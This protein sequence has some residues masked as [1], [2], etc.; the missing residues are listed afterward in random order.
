MCAVRLLRVSV[1]ERISAAAEDF[2]LQVEKGGETAEIPAL[3]ALLTER[4]TAAAEEIIGLL[5]ETVAE[6][7]G[8]VERS[9]REICRQRRLLDAVLKP[10]VR[11]H[12][13]ALPSDILKVIV[14]EDELQQRSPSPDQEDAEPPH[15][16]EEEEELWSSQEGEQL[17]GLE[18]AEISRST[19][20]PVPVK[21][22]DD[23]EKPQ[24]SQLH[25]TQ[26]EA[27][28]EA[29]PSGCGSAELIKP[30]A[31]AESE[32]ST[33]SDTHL[34]PGAED[35]ASDSSDTEVSDGDWEDTREPEAG[36]KPLRNSR[37]TVIDFNCNTVERS[38]S[39]SECGQRFGRKPH[40]NAHMRIHTG[41]KPFSCS[42]CGKRF[43]QKGN[44]VSHM[45]LHTGEKPFSCSV[46]KKRFRYSGDVSRHMRIHTG[47]KKSSGTDTGS[48][49]TRTSGPHRR[50]PPS[51]DDQTP[52]PEADAADDGWRESGE[53]L[54]HLN[55]QRNEDV[56]A[57]ETRCSSDKESFSCSECGRTFCRKDHLMSHM[58]T[59][60]GE[61]PFSCSVCQKRFSCSGNILAHMRIHTGEKP[62]QCSFCSKSFSQK[63]T[64]QLH[65]RIHTGEKPFSCPFCDKRFAHKRRM[66]LHMSVHTEEKRFSCS[67]CDKR[68]TWYTQLK[69][70][71]C[72]GGSSQLR[73]SQT[74]KKVPAKES[75]SCSECGKT[76]S[77]KGNLKT[78]MRIHTGEKPFSCS[79]CGKSFKQ[80][81]HL[82]EHMTIHTGEKLY[83]CSVCGKGFNKKLLVKNHT[84]DVT[85][86]E[87]Q[88]LG[89]D[90]I[91]VRITVFSCDSVK[92]SG[93]RDLKDSLRRRLLSAVRH[94]LFGHFERTVSDYEKELDRSR[95]LL[96]MVSNTDSK[97]RGADVQQQ[98]VRKD[99]SPSERRDRSP[100]LD[101]EDPEP[102]HIKEEEE[103][104]CLTQRPAGADGGNCG[105][106]ESSTNP[107]SDRRSRADARDKASDCES[108]DSD[109][110]W[111]DPHRKFRCSKCG[112]TCSQRGNLNIHMRTHT[113]EK[114]FSCSVCGKRFTQKV[115]LH[116]HLKIHTGEK[117]FSCSVCGKSFRQKGPLKYHMLTHTGVKPFS[118]SVCNKR[119]RWSSQIRVHKCVDESPQHH[120]GKREKPLS[121]SEC[122][123][124][125]PNN[126]LLKIHTRIHKGKKLLTCSVCGLQRQFSSQMEIHMRSHTGE[127]PYSCSICGKKF[128]QRGIMMQH[129]AIHSGVKPFGCS[130]CGRRFF[131][132]FQIKKHKCAGR[133]QPIR[134]HFTAEDCGRSGLS[135]TLD[136]DKRFKLDLNKKTEAFDESDDTVDIEFWKDVRQH[137]S[138]LTYQRKRK[139]CADDGNNPG[140]KAMN[141]SD[142]DATTGS[143][144]E[145]SDDGQRQRPPASTESKHEDVS[146]RDAAFD[147]DGKPFVSSEG[148]KAAEVS[149]TLQTHLR[150]R[151]G[152]KPFSCFFCG[153]GFTTGG[154]LTRHVSVHTGEKLLSCII[155]EQS[156]AAESECFSHTCVGAPPHITASKAFSC[157]Q[158]G[159]AFVRKHQLQ[160]HTRLHCGVKPLGRS[161]CGERFAKRESFH[162]TCHAGQKSLRC[163]VCKTG[164][165]D[166]ESLIQHMR[167][168]TRQTQFSCSVCGKEFAWRRY[169]TKHMEVH[170]KERLRSCGVCDRGLSHQT[171]TEDSTEAESPAVDGEDRGGPGTTRTSAPDRHL[172]PGRDDQTL[173]SCEPETDDDGFWKESR[174]RESSSNCV[175][176]EMCEREM[177]SNAESDSNAPSADRGFWTDNRKLVSRLKP[178]RPDEVSQSVSTDCSQTTGEKLMSGSTS[179]EQFPQREGLSQH[180]AL[181]TGALHTGALHTGALHTGAHREAKQEDP[182]P[183]LIKEEWDELQGLEEAEISRSTFSRV[184]VKTEDDEDKPQS[185]QLHQSHTEET[186]GGPGPGPARTSDPDRR[187]QSD[188]DEKT[189]DSSEPE[190][191]D[192]DFWKE[193]RKPQSDLGSLT[194]N[195]SADGDVDRGSGK[196]RFSCS[197]EKAS[198]S[199]GPESD[200]SVDSDFWKESRKPQLSPNSVKSSDAS[201]SD[202]RCNGVRKPYGCSEC[203]KRFLYVCHMKAHMR[204]HS[205]ETPFFCS[206]CGQ[207]CLY[208]SH[209]KIHMRT[210]TGEKPFVCPVCGKKYAHKASMQSHMSVHTVDKQ[211]SCTVCDR[212]FAWFTELKYHQCVGE[213][214]SS[215]QNK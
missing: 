205:V 203:G 49:P 160:V 88:K 159:K 100:R 14:G 67:V 59:H 77:L 87:P 106:S 212:S 176:D 148:Q 69:T 22:E 29:E 186:C 128:T 142:G 20:S 183:P 46:C 107:D 65:M 56:S 130:D 125:F 30:E 191:D 215:F 164:F 80:N 111:E 5:E 167:I 182:E 36:V 129:M 71:K 66:T 102:L 86:S 8:R 188:S 38:F 4:L 85:V 23:E 73:Q 152:E 154:N 119:F 74:E 90:V 165:G 177:R 84:S 118:C 83:K 153:K 101:Q 121:C 122:D 120:R 149:H 134:V 55:S 145:E 43:S 113:G 123:E 201:E 214:S 141:C 27:Q 98:L 76:F 192:S 47:K 6:Y 70:H 172:Q 33:N 137:Q 168:H 146:V 196:I 208:R 50:V 53:P 39:C 105:G 10:E 112:K 21:T 144:D 157:S 143:K 136:P 175:K 37:V 210:H 58:R 131:W 116:Y 64:L 95:K 140:K 104:L 19:F 178:V 200:D 96:D 207:K 72:V 40:L 92:M 114:P 110:D 197:D 206:V 31:D 169:L 94:D 166:R 93:L 42:F 60:T 170:A 63:G 193:S 138:G 17:Q 45:R 12:R 1:H 204:R 161:A 75:F 32:A 126:S 109:R 35:K 41:E 2:L 99:E 151:T 7:E 190:T 34:Q 162:V 187:L 209:L 156:F 78:H 124:T 147:S 54:S 16:K 103:E 180:W 127:R 3:R 68:F 202:V 57:G 48:E 81:V 62:F 51:A 195:E 52:E 173:D 133:S 199:L 174:K 135:R 181:H 97:R 44:S 150:C 139:V 25:H 82:T 9:E 89:P 185:S 79:V 189:S 158:C 61:K 117:P 91:R 179:G 132:H 108:G 211:Y 115:G 194:I 28:Q 26:Q 24:S 15:I 171:H 18:E 184:P 155:C 163:S 11:L 13:A 198:E 213:S